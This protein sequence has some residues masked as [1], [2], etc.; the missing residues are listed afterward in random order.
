MS[1]V[2]LK[3]KTREGTGKGVARK[4]RAEGRIPAV[5][6]GHKTK[7]INLSIDGKAFED[8]FRSVSIESTVI[9]LE[10]EGGPKKPMKILIR[11]I[12]R[13]PYRD[14]ILHLD[15]Y[16]ISMKEAVTVEVPI[17]LLE[18]PV[19][20]RT[21][22]GILQHQLREVQI[23]CLPGEIPEKIE[24]DVSEL[25]IGESIHVGDLK[26]EGVDLLSDPDGL[27]ATVLPPTVIKEEVKPEVEEEEALE[28]ELV[29]KE[30]EEEAEPAAAEGGKA[31][32]EKEE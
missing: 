10:V 32:P 26:L 27:V 15:F 30:K 24:L 3:A 20:V 8:L 1:E 28:P 14:K 6:Y 12:Q 17:S 25:S 9:N 16:Q 11:E 4:I 7:P 21:E 13:H 22:G 23:S 29:S 18:V 19:G 5:V 2:V 31:K